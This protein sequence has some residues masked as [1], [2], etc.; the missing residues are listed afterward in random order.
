MNLWRG[1]RELELFL[2]I[3][4]HRLTVLSRIL[5]KRFSALLFYWPA[6][7]GDGGRGT[8]ALLGIS[9]V[10]SVASFHVRNRGADDGYH[11]LS[12]DPVVG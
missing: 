9:P 5:C 6:S 2:G 11:L 1:L 7:A 4:C 8:R 3:C 12:F 10:C